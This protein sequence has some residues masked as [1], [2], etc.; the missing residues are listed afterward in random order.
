MLCVEFIVVT[1][2]VNIVQCY[3]V[4]FGV[5]CGYS[6]VDIVQWYRVVCGV[7]CGYSNSRYRAIVLCFVW[8]FLWLQLQ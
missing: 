2:T 7:Y 4:V 3:C 6:K 5:Y 1:A 8:S